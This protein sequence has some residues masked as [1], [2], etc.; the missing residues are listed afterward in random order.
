MLSYITDPAAPS[1]LSRRAF[2]PPDTQANEALI[3]VRA[4]AVSRGETSLLQM[5]PN[6]FRP[7]QEV[8]GIVVKAA[9]D[10]SGPQVGAHVVGLTEG[11]GWSELATVPALQLGVIPSDVG[12]DRALTMISGV[13][14]YRALCERGELRGRCVL[15]TGATGAVGYM[16]VQLALL[17]GADVTA[18][19]SGPHRAGLLQ[20][21]PALKV[22]TSL[23]GVEDRYDM[24]LDGVGGPVLTQCVRRLAPAGL[25]LTYGALTGQPTVISPG[26]FRPAPGARLGAYFIWQS[27]LATLGRD[28]EMLMGWCA[29]GKL[30]ALVGRALDWSKTAEMV[31][32][33][34]SR[35]VVGKGVLTIAW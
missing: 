1:G 22:L 6:G 5:R 19:V 35:A 17:E 9:A 25:V 34:R 13:M 24:I 30:S 26:D 12:F 20:H 18:L 32:A 31:D 16:G 7:G 3:E 29:D 8:A 21:I 2:A 28:L 14:A 10:G 11:Q 15:V 4:Y 27:D 23:E 33:I